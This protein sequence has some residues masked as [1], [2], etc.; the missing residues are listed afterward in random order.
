M[1]SSQSKRAR[2]S[3]TLAVVASLMSVL[4]AYSPVGSATAR[5]TVDNISSTTSTTVASSVKTANLAGFRAGNIISD[6][7]FFNSGSMTEAQIQ[8]F[9]QSKVPNCQPGYTCLKDKRDTSRTTTADAMCGAHA[10]AENESAST[11]IFK[12]AQACGINP[13]VLLVT[14]QKEQG[15]V[16][17][18]WPSDWRYTIAMGQGCPDTAAC[19][20][21]Y[22]GFF[23][24]VYGAAWQMKRYANPSGT[25]QYFT[26]YAPG[27]TWN[28]LYNPN[29]GCGS[30][31]VYIENQAT[32]N[33]YYYTPYQPNRAALDAG[34]GEGDGCSSYGNR[35]FYQYF[36]DWFGSTS[37]AT[38]GAIGA[39]WSGT[40]GASGWVGAP[41]AEMVWDPANG[42][43]W[44]QRF[45]NATIYAKAAGGTS[46]LR[47]SS[48]LHLT[49]QAAGGSAGGWGWPNGDESC[50]SGGCAISFQGGSL[51]WNNRTGAVHPVVGAIN[52]AW[53]ASGGVAGMLRSAEAAERYSSDGGG[54]WIQSFTGGTVFVKQGG[55]TTSFWS[56]SGLIARYL[57][58][59][60]ASSGLG[61]PTRDEA[62][63]TGVGC[64]IEF[65]GGILT[66]N[67]SDGAINTV[68]GFFAQTWAA[69][70]GLNQIGPAR[71]SMKSTSGGWTQDFRRGTYYLKSDGAL[72]T[73]NAISALHD[74][75]RA[76]GAQG[77]SFGWP[78]SPE[79]CA[80]GAG[81]AVEFEGGT[82][83]WEMST[84]IVAAMSVTMATGWAQA[85]R[86]GSWTGAPVADGVR[87]TGAAPGTVQNF[88]NAIG[89]QRDGS[90]VVFHKNASALAATYRAL[91][92][93]TGDL[94]WPSA[95]ESCGDGRC[96][97]QFERGSLVWE[98]ATGRITRG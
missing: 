19:D 21:R 53:I 33:L 93:P 22:Y 45:M 72:I 5:V 79:A 17:H 83:S 77:G 24:Q 76:R 14:L 71:T 37:I 29:Q 54:G 58:M 65:D 35:N 32:A 34:Y 8:S 42:G 60:G 43:G 96:T 30:G 18:T 75:Y 1:Q 91:G 12:V 25:S 95:G 15:L 11:I 97:L 57:S 63:V 49:Y 67:L 64:A 55:V 20:T 13:Q 61:W 68:S 88:R 92:G 23:N 39:A 70:D 56:G 48:L 44:Y 85:G 84:G 38:H 2:R 78:V 80:A 66:W 62:C 9:L 7:T 87:V 40:G 6:A 36:T 50:G 81:C 4:I 94:G 98:G 69:N 89:Y 73:L 90:A 51:L 3:V 10:G 59:G 46:I 27:R 86:F 28:V 16:T 41:V 47:A 31:P 26:W 82:L 74:T 52:V